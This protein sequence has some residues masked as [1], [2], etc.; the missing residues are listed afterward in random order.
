MNVTSSIPNNTLFTS[1]FFSFLEK[2]MSI[3]VFR[4]LPSFYIIILC[5]LT[6]HL[7]RHFSRYLSHQNSTEGG[8]M[9]LL[10]VELLFRCY[11][12]VNAVD[13]VGVGYSM[14]RL[15][16]YLS[17]NFLSHPLPPQL[18]FL[19]ISFMLTKFLKSKKSIVMSS[20][21]YLNFEFLL[22]KIIHKK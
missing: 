19:L 5:I 17:R 14:R 7:L 21:K 3:L 11:F 18:Q 9:G 10:A 4:R 16:V 6:L 22:F 8:R 13:M 1:S 2:N 20:I 12:H 15:K